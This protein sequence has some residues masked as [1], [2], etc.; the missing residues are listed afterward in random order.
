MLVEL[1]VD[2]YAV[3]ERARIRFHAGLNLL[4]GETGSGKSIVVDAL[5]LLF[6]ARASPGVVRTGAGRARVSG[7]F[8]VEPSPALRA[9]LEPAGVEIEDGEL[10]VEREIQ[11]NGKSR[12]FLGNRPVTAALLKA[13]APHLGD[14]HGQHE[15]QELFSPETQLDLLDQF[16]AS[17]PLLEKTGACFE[18]WRSLRRQLEDLDRGEQDKLQLLD[19]WRFQFREIETAALKPGEDQDLEA[20]RRILQN[21]S[22]LQE[23]LSAAF[24]ALYDAPGSAATQIST[25]RKR[26]DELVRIDPELSGVLEA[27]KPAEIAVDEASREL[28]SYLG[29]LEADPARL[30]HVEGRLAAIDKLKRKYGASINEILAFFADLGAKL[31]VAGDASGYRARLARELE[32]AAAAYRAAAAELTA[33]RRDASSSLDKA[34]RTELAQLAME[35]TRFET[36]VSAAEWS[37][38]GADQVRFLISPNPGEEPR[39]LDRIASGGELS[40]IALALKTS[41]SSRVSPARGGSGRKEE[42]RTVPTLVFDEVDSGIG[43]RTAESVGRRLRKL[44]AGTQVLC[45]THLPQIAGFADHHYLVEK[46]SGDGRTV[47]TVQELD[48]AQRAREIGRMLSGERLTDE[49]LKNAERLIKLASQS[50]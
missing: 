33:L 16:A 48:A 14:I 9:L 35:G 5:G 2:S 47:A 36:N 12:A 21:V 1:V 25:A 11:A 20:E 31:E 43:G 42:R 10:L 24:E 6:G 37:P 41:I 29:R 26:L 40:R 34:V 4:T 32:E 46:A 15:T 50:V 39:P 44:A 28:R 38:R 49:A 13:L 17:G 23:N 18:R 22:R 30:D 27:L 3:V 19:L 8:E 45:V 7:I